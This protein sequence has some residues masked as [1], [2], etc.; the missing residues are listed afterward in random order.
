MN[1]NG[2]VGKQCNVYIPTDFTSNPLTTNVFKFTVCRGS[3]LAKSLALSTITSSSSVTSTGNPFLRTNKFKS[4]LT[5]VIFEG[6]C[7]F[8]F[9]QPVRTHKIDVAMEKC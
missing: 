6:V 5:F 2:E 7:S 9:N 4:K 1:L 8:V 3:N